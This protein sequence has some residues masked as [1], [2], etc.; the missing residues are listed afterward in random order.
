MK[1]TFYE[2]SE[3]YINSASN[4]WQTQTLQNPILSKEGLDGVGSPLL[5]SFMQPWTPR[6]FPQKIS[7]GCAGLVCCS[8][9]FIS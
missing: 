1:T 9:L 2:A 5:L 4:N 7:S 3:W 8:F 6:G